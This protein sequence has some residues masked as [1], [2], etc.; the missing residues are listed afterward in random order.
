[1]KNGLTA[2]QKYLHLQKIRA[3]NLLSIFFLLYS[4]LLL[5][6][7]FFKIH[8][9]ASLPAFNWAPGYWEIAQDT[10]LT[11]VIPLASYVLVNPTSEKGRIQSHL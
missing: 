1:M 5:L 3:S 6:S 10:G 4:I 8:I 9:P 7:L 2:F 11:R